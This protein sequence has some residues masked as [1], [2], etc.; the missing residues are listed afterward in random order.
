MSELLAEDTKIVFIRNGLNCRGVIRGCWV[1][2]PETIL[3]VVETEDVVDAPY[4]SV[5]VDSESITAHAEE[6]CSDFEK[7]WDKQRELRTTFEWADYTWGDG[8]DM[9]YDYIHDSNS[10]SENDRHKALAEI[11]WEAAQNACRSQPTG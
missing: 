8:D 7:W 4:T 1:V 10:C 5:I 3:Y 11:V 6:A 9:S 2:S